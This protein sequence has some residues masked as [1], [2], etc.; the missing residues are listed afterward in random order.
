MKLNKI[1]KCTTLAVASAGM[2][3]AAEDHLVLEAKGESNGKHV[4]LIAG[5]EEYRSE[6][7]MPMMAHVLSN[8][9]FKCTVLFSMDKQNK[10]VDPLNLTNL[11]NSESLDSADAIVMCIR[12]RNWEDKDFMKFESAFERGVPI[13]A[14]RTSTHAFKTKPKSKWAKYSF[15]A[16]ANTGWEKGFGRQ[17]LGEAWVSHHGKHKFE[18]TRTHIEKGQEAN[19]VLN[20]VGEIFCTSD[21]YEAHP[22]EPSTILLRGEV[23]ESFEPDSA[24]VEAKNSPMMPVAWTREYK[25]ESGTVNKVLTTTM[26][27]ATD[28]VD[29]DLRRLVV[30]GVYWGTG[31][32]V[33]AKADVTINGTYEPTFYV[34]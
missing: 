16:K 15:N 25:H 33:P 22:L 6:E 29:E 24:G 12:F 5:D 34:F 2:V 27:A 14:L 31:L 13:V 4:V 32:E 7:S 11:S 9:G 18:A 28:L 21:T 10:F 26:G 1:I 20:G 19:P 30:N 17:V 8:N 3:N 23:T